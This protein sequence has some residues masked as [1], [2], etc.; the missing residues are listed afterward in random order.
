VVSQRRKTMTIS[1]HEDEIRIFF[2]AHKGSSGRAS[3]E[4]ARLIRKI[5]RDD[6]TPAHIWEN[7]KTLHGIAWGEGGYEH[8]DMKPIFRRFFNILDNETLT[9]ILDYATREWK[10]HDGCDN[11][12]IWHGLLQAIG[13][14]NIPARRKRKILMDVSEPGS[15]PGA[16]WAAVEAL[17]RSGESRAA[18]QLKRTIQR[19]KEQ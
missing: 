6:G 11:R 16:D 19:R 7:A 9:S 13:D 17:E 10:E 1:I 15:Y 3:R 12:I 4:A 5:F 14:S 8:D 2:E 18:R